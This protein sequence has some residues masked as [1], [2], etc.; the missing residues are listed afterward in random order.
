[1]VSIHQAPY[2]PNHSNSPRLRMTP[3]DHV[4]LP[5]FL[6]PLIPLNRVRFKFKQDCS[7][8]ILDGFWVLN[9]WL[10]GYSL[11]GFKLEFSLAN[12]DSFTE[13]LAV[14]LYYSH[15][16]IVVLWRPNLCR[17]VESRASSHSKPWR[18]PYPALL[19]PATRKL[20]PCKCRFNINTG[21][22]YYPHRNPLK[23]EPTT[24]AIQHP[25]KTLNLPVRLKLCGSLNAVFELIFTSS[26]LRSRHRIN[27]VTLPLRTQPSPFECSTVIPRSTRRSLYYFH[28]NPGPTQRCTSSAAPHRT[29]EGTQVTFKYPHPHPTRQARAA[30]A[31]PDSETD[32]GGLQAVCADESTSTPILEFEFEVS[33]TIDLLARFKLSKPRYGLLPSFHLTVLALTASHRYGDVYGGL[34]TG[35]GGGGGVGVEIA[36]G[37]DGVCALRACVAPVIGASTT[38]LAVQ[39]RRSIHAGHSQLPCSL[40]VC[41]DA[42][43]DG[44]HA[45]ARVRGTSALGSGGRCDDDGGGGEGEGA[46]GRERRGGERGRQREREM[47]REELATGKRVQ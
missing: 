42:T 1:M 31:V 30:V 14:P 26:S 17:R 5:Y 45:C 47:R 22:S 32:P 37:E 20:S 34:G 46:K 7:T 9:G 8:L 19:N 15:R 38:T 13:T 25:G 43:T 39:Q 3:T 4:R 16:D 11:S 23:A 40:D 33:L 36:R 24:R 44:V 28:L 35:R 29:S 6:C 21:L 12:G 10:H 2:V 18:G 27:A 41:G